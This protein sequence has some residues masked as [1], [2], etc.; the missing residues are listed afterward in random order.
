MSLS[1]AAGARAGPHQGLA[2]RVSQTWDVWPGG[3]RAPGR[4]CGGLASDPHSTTSGASVATR[5]PLA[6]CREPVAP[7]PAAA[8]RGRGCSCLL[9]VFL[10]AAAVFA[11]L[12]SW[13]LDR[14]LARGEARAVDAATAAASA[15][16][17]A[18]AEVLAP[19]SGV[20]SGHRRAGTSR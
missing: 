1:C 7:A 5:L 10:V 14:A 2:G 11:R 4:S 16:P 8:A 12:G 3:S 18:L 6:P 20:H 19:Q 9:V 13:Q 15:A 17:V